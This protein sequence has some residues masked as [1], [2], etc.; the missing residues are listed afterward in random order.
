MTRTRLVA[1]VAAVWRLGQCLPRWLSRSLLQ[2]WMLATPRCSRQACDG[3]CC[4]AFD[5]TNVVTGETMC[6]L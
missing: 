4:S 1:L 5:V 3:I 6:Y 2:R